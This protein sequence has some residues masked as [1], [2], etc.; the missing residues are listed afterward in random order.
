MHYLYSVP[1]LTQGSCGNGGVGVALLTRFVTNCPCESGQVIY[2]PS[3]TI[4]TGWG[5]SIEELS[6]L[7]GPAEV[8]P[9]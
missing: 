6:V 7:Q 9:A 5:E 1:A 2:L 3:A 4:R 8:T